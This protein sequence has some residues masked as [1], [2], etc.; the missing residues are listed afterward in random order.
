MGDYPDHKP[1]IRCDASLEALP[2]PNV[3]RQASKLTRRFESDS[4]RHDTQRDTQNVPLE[5]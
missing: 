5:G 2:A 4:T 3:R 1:S